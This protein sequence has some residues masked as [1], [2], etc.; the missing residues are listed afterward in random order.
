METVDGTLCAFLSVDFCNEGRFKFM[1]KVGYFLVAVVALLAGSMFIPA[2]PLGP[3]VANATPAVPEP[4]S[5][6]LL[7]TGIVGLARYL[8]KR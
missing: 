5:L 8:R 1:R 3:Q 2:G 7:G 6:I 4:S